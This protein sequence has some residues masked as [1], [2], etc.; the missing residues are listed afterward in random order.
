MN[1]RIYQ[2]RHREAYFVIVFVTAFLVALL[3]TGKPDYT[4]S[5]DLYDLIL[6]YIMTIK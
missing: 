5:A 1:M 3:V 2:S 6:R 4:I